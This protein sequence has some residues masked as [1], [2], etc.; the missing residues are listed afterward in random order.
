MAAMV[1][2]Q[3]RYY[4]CDVVIRLPDSIQ[5]MQ[6]IRSTNTLIEKR[7]LKYFFLSPLLEVAF[8]F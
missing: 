3:E 5:K 4:D 2:K 8:H 6:G 7:K 1:C